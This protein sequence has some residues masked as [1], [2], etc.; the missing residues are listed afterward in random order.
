MRNNHFA[1]V[2]GADAK[3]E[4]TRRRSVMDRSASRR[5]FLQD[6]TAL[7]AAGSVSVAFGAADAHADEPRPSRTGA[8]GHPAGARIRHDGHAR[9]SA[10][11]S[12]DWPRDIAERGKGS[13]GPVA[14]SPERQPAADR[15]A[16]A[17]AFTR[18]REGRPRRGRQ[19][20]SLWT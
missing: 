8:A 5:R 16:D 9:S 18:D 17:R 1:D 6:I 4:S 7:G 3:V 19:G 14:L 15:R 13:D 20:Q 12:D 2:A 11:P 10:D